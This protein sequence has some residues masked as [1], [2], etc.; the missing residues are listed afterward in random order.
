MKKLLFVLLLAFAGTGVFA[1]VKPNSSGPVYANGDSYGY[2]VDEQPGAISYDWSVQGNTNATIYPAWDTA[3]DIIF[4][5]A[6]FEDVICTVTTA[7]TSYPLYA[8]VEVFAA[9]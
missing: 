9:P 1:Q 6:G 2:Y 5:N 8:Y 7:T 3:I 4:S